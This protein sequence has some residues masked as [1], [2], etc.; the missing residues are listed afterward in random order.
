MFSES[1]AGGNNWFFSRSFHKQTQ[2]KCVSAK[3]N[4]KAIF[5]DSICWNTFS[6]F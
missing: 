1:I 4:P 5:G 6:G 2:Q 3:D